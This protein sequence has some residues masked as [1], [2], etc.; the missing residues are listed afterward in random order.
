MHL[1]RIW[2]S[3][4]NVP[5]IINM[6]ILVAWRLSLIRAK[7]FFMVAE[8]NQDLVAPALR[9]MPIE[10]VSVRVRE[11]PHWERERLLVLCLG[12]NG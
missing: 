4:L 7:D 10:V 8:C 9:H 12:Q 3:S 5:L 11:H 2:L 6:E 1:I